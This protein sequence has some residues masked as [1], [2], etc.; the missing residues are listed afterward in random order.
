MLGIATDVCSALSYMHGSGVVHGDLKAANVLLAPNAKATPIGAAAAG[1]RRYTAK[2]A[3]FGQSTVADGSR[4]AAACA[5]QHQVH[6]SAAGAFP[7]PGAPVDPAVVAAVASAAAPPASGCF[8]F[9]HA[10]PE[11]FHGAAPSYASD[12]YALGV[13]L[14]ELVSQRRPYAQ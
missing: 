13:L 7:T 14:W 9:T 12:V 6:D 5:A 3:D 2:L 10:A 11:L 8:T 1:S 4:L